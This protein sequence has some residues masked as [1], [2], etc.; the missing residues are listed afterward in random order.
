MIG[1]NSPKKCYGGGEVELLSGCFS[2]DSICHNTR[3]CY[4]WGRTID[5][6]KALNGCEK[7]VYF[8]SYEP[9]AYCHDLPDSLVSEVA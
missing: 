2:C 7:W 9:G 1:T 8:D 5:K 4:F 6:Q 3:F